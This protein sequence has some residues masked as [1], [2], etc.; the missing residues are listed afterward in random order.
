M[1]MPKNQPANLIIDGMP[2]HN[3][4]QT[5]SGDEG[6]LSVDEEIELA[7]QNI[8]SGTGEEI[9]QD[10]TF[11]AE[12][13]VAGD[14]T[15]S[16]PLPELDPHHHHETQSSL[17]ETIGGSLVDVS[18]EYTRNLACSTKQPTEEERNACANDRSR[19]ALRNWYK[20]YNEL[21]AYKNEHGN[22]DVPQKYTCKRLANFVNKQRME[23]NRSDDNKHQ[24][25][26]TARRISLLEDLGFQWSRRKGEISWEK[27]YAE[28]K[29]F[30]NRN[31]HCHVPTKRGALGRWVSTQ[32]S[33]FKHKLL[34][35]DRIEKLNKIGF[36]WCMKEVQRGYSEK[37]QKENDDG[38]SHGDIDD[39]DDDG[40]KSDNAYEVSMPS[41]KY[42]LLF[43]FL[44]FLSYWPIRQDEITRMARHQGKDDEGPGGS[45]G[46]AV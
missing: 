8:F 17:P 13:D 44:L 4:D 37:V 11:R 30:K 40:K 32:R 2:S 35:N 45:S 9:M 14:Q 25:K 42:I 18:S 31:G 19:N 28:M 7:A 27:S 29:K 26:M 22:C 21:V 16:N 46:I 12:E 38:E 1:I 24:T 23:K 43:Q 3:G 6:K 33:K 5:N 41:F 36:K 15:N 10:V 34:S 20:R 39:D